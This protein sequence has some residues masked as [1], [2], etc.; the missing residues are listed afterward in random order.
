MNLP[1]WMR[2]FCPSYIGI[3]Y[4]HWCGAKNTHE[5]QNDPEPIDVGDRACMIHDFALRES[6]QDDKLKADAELWR[7][8]KNWRPKRL[9]AKIYRKLI[10]IT[11]KNKYCK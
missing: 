3:K 8:W 11:F 6:S 2:K 1:N 10:L 9:W 7:K 5:F 4:G